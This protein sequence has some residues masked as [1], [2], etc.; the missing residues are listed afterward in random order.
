MLIRSGAKVEG[1]KVVPVFHILKAN[2]RI[3]LQLLLSHQ[4]LITIVHLALID[5]WNEG[6]PLNVRSSCP[7]GRMSGFWH[8]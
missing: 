4:K 5:R 3:K 1:S 8:E 6:V 2:G 7:K